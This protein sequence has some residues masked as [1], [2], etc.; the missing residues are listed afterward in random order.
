MYLIS[1]VIICGIIEVLLTL[2]FEGIIHYLK[3]AE[4]DKGTVFLS[5]AAVHV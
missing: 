1:I 3:T 5:H 4:R 2:D